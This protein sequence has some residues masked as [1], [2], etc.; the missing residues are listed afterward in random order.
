MSSASQPIGV[1][2]EIVKELQRVSDYEA[3]LRQAQDEKTITFL[4]ELLKI[5]SKGIEALREKER[6][7]LQA[8]RG[9]G[10]PVFHH[11]LNSSYVT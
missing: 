11:L 9:G 10:L 8:Q 1:Q 5:L 7:V 4:R 6:I 3:Q 2:Q